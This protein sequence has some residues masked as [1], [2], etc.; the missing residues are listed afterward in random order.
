MDFQS[1]QHELDG[2]EVHPTSSA[3]R[4]LSPAVHPQIVLHADDFGMNRE[5][6]DG[7]VLGFAEGLLTSTSLLANAPDAGRALGLWKQLAQDQLARSL[8]SNQARWRL[9]DGDQPFDLGAHVNLT[10]GRPMI[11]DRY[12]VALL[13][14]QGRFPGIFGLFRRL[15]GHGRR[16]HGAIEAELSRQI[17]FLFD[18]GIQPTHLN[19]HEYVE[20]LPAVREVVVGLLDKFRITAVRIAVERM[21]PSL[22]GAG[23]S[24]IVVGLRARAHQAYARR[25]EARIQG[26]AVSR[27][28][29]FL[30]VGRAARVDIDYLRRALTGPQ[31]FSLLEVC[32]HPAASRATE[33]AGRGDGW[34]DPLAALRPAELRMVLSAE[35]ADFLQSQHL[36]LGRVGGRQND[37]ELKAPAIVRVGRGQALAKVPA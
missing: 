17:E 37:C 16:F 6:T 31:P 19:G 22:P 7:I 33:L 35:L 8:A 15:W 28:D 4:I 29:T 26:L 18:H 12:P 10:Q 36:R 9:G 13:D 21:K 27:P 24:R 14:R 30:G 34:D 1:V 32:L 23:S 11:G 25:F 3:A 2:L 5:V 20:M